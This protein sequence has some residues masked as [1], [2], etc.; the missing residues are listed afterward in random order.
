MLSLRY[1]CITQCARKDELETLVGPEE[2]HKTEDMTFTEME[3]GR[4]LQDEG[5]KAV[6]TF[7]ETLYARGDCAKRCA[8]V[9]I[10]EL[11]ECHILKTSNE[12]GKGVNRR[13]DVVVNKHNKAQ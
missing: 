9:K 1:R 6:T 2:I 7:P 3:G 8:L 12:F 10:S 13:L 11:F 4:G 5:K